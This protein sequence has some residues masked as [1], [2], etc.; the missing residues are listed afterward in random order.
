MLVSELGWYVVLSQ[1]CDIARTT[2]V[3]LCIVACW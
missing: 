3:E 1:D 2:E